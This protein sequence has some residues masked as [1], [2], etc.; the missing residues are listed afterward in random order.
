[1]WM[2]GTVPLGYA[3]KDRKLVINEAESDG[4]RLIP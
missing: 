4:V 3:V 2:G 1:M